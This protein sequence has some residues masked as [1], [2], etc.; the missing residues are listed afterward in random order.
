VDINPEKDSGS[1]VLL[2]VLDSAINPQTDKTVLF[3]S[4][5]E[6]ILYVD[7]ERQILEAGRRFLTH[8]GYRVTALTSSLEAREVFRSRPQDFDLVITDL[9]MPLITGLDLAADIAKIRPDLPI[10][11]Y[12][13][14]CESVSPE[15]VSQSG[16]REI[17]KKPANIANLAGIIRRLLDSEED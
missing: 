6:R 2:S 3:T 11:L 17:I 1:Q 8:L 13:G 16:I 14:Y 5:K 12:S 7:D 15:I 9:N 10:I 4:V